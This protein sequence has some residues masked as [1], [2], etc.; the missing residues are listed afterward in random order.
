MLM[1]ISSVHS[2]C[3]IV[4]AFSLRICPYNVHGFSETKREYIQGLLDSHDIVMLQGHWLYD[5]Q[6]HVIQNR[7]RDISLRC[8]P[9]MNDNCLSAG[10][11][12]Y[13][14]CAILWKSPLSCIVSIVLVNIHGTRLLL[15]CL[16]VPCDT[17]Y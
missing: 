1:V 11:R 15:W 17:S 13:G 4:M 6:M 12:G 2:I 7:F 5:S 16:Y 9:G 8:V 10:G 14:G 3:A